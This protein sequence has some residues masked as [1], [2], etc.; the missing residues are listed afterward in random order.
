MP[1]NP[2]VFISLSAVFISLYFNPSLADPFNSPKLWALMML[3]SWLLGYIVIFLI[4]KRKSLVKTEKIFF[5]IIATFTLS[6]LYSSLTTKV[7]FTAFFGEQ[8]RRLGF[9]FYLFMGIFMLASGLFYSINNLSV[10][11]KCAI[12]LG[13][14]FAAYGTL[15]AYGQDFIS[16]NNPYNS[17]ILTLGNPNFASA[18]MSILAVIIFNY[19]TIAK[20]VYQLPLLAL[21]TYI[22]ILIALSQSR[23]GLIAFGI[24]ISVVILIRIFWLSRNL[25]IVVAAILFCLFNLVI[26]A[27]LQ[28]GPFAQAIYKNSVSLRGFY[29]RAGLEMFQ[30]K[31]LT[32]VGVDSYGDYFREFREKLYPLTYGYQISSDNAHNVPIQIFSTTGALVGILYLTLIIF[33]ALIGIKQLKQKDSKENRLALGIFGAWV[34]F[35]A[36]SVISIDNVGL[37][38]WGWILGGTVIG[39]YTSTKGDNS[40]HTLVKIQKMNKS[41]VIVK[42]KLVS[43]T[44]TLLAILIC[45]ALYQ[46]EKYLYQLTSYVNP[47]SIKQIQEFEFAAKKFE[48]ARLVEPAYKFRYANILFQ[49]NRFDKSKEIVNRLLKSNPNSFDYL[50]GCAQIYTFESDWKQVIMC[51]T[52]LTQI[53]PWNAE[54]YFQLAFAQ[55]MINDFASASVNYE[56]ILSF[57]GESPEAIKAKESLEKIKSK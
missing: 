9:I 14:I 44:V 27:M 56:K 43:G 48:S 18:L 7:T 50:N 41:S 6:M 23:Q 1:L 20:R 42:Q 46:G 5:G 3:G 37:T 2:T 45:S 30:S 36:Q 21:G 40:N 19:I 12:T 4:S 32:G 47:G 54:N 38:I 34:T 33:I 25:G 11:Y 26:L 29:W 13:I 8:Q 28:V 39:I 22:I 49:I 35:Q 17:I 55:E 10:L 51:R 53:D 57:A 24:G 31:I 15:Q 52:Q 16:W